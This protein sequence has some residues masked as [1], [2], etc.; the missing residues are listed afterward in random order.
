MAHRHLAGMGD[1]LGGWGR[2]A[3]GGV[4][5]FILPI[6]PRGSLVEPYVQVLAARLREC[7]EMADNPRLR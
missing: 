1:G 6:S 3:E 7:L 4:R 2:V 5:L